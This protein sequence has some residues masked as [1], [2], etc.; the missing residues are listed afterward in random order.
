MHSHANSPHCTPRMERERQTVELLS[1]ERRA[2]AAALDARVSEVQSTAGGDWWRG[3]GSG[4]RGAVANRGA[5]KL[6]TETVGL[7]SEPGA[8]GKGL[9]ETPSSGP[10]PQ[11]RLAS[12]SWSSCVYLPLPSPLVPSSSPPSLLPLLTC[13][14]RSLAPSSPPAEPRPNAYIPESLGIPKPYGGFAPFKPQEPGSTM[15]H[16]RK[17]QPKEVVI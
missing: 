12:R 13:R 8:V 15:R 6:Q 16:I 9:S 7:H 3:A 17:P 11:G 1:D 14:P 4:A 2:V 10:L 5:A